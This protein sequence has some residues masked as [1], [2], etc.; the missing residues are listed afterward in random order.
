MVSEVCYFL[1][2]YSVTILSSLLSLFFPLEN[3]SIIYGRRLSCNLYSSIS[4]ILRNYLYIFINP[5]YFSLQTPIL[6]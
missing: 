6:V 4:S 1:V 2:K 5:G 3:L